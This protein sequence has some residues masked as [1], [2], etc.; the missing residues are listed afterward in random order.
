MFTVYNPLPSYN[1]LGGCIGDKYGRS[2]KC[3]TNGGISESRKYWKILL[4]TKT[5]TYLSKMFISE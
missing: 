4:G 2:P 1:K 5:L 3:A